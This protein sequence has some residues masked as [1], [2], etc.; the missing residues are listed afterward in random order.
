MTTIGTDPEF[1]LT[2]DNKIYSAIN[3][4]KHDK[5][6]RKKIKNYY[7]YHDNV[8]AE[9][10]IPPASDKEAFI[11]NIK[12]GLELY[13]KL[14][15]PYNLKT[16]SAHIFDEDQLDCEE[17]FEI[18]CVPEFCAYELEYI[19]PDDSVLRLSNLRTAGGHI[20]IGDKHLV[21]TEEAEFVPFPVH[22]FNNI[23]C[24]RMMD[25]FV[26]V[27][28]LYLDKDPTAIKRK[29]LYGKAG[30]CRFPK[31]GVE[32]RSI[33]NFWL[34]SP[35]LAGLIFDLSCFV[36]NFIK[37]NRHLSFW[38]INYDKLCDINNWR[39]KTFNI[40]D[41][42][43]CHKYDSD[44]LIKLINNHEKSNDS[45]FFLNFIFKILPKNLVDQIKIEI[46]KKYSDNILD[47][48]GI[49]DK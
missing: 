37:E 19:I 31:Y 1:M 13:S 23:Y 10:T 22:E 48:W 18:A 11:Q 14:V 20:H 29:A 7:F 9:C 26:G 27:V 6:K 46:D 24:I 33:G 32:Y 17:A 25:L 12:T 3:I 41:C 8:L 2:K 16:Q 36:S 45:L 49:N 28:S 4:I 30:R 15:S 34:N 44:K 35:E 5:D 43:K 40:S 42:H 38:S 39:D 47:N 21:Y